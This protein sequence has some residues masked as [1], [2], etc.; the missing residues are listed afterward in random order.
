MIR[1]KVEITVNFTRACITVF[2]PYNNNE[3]TFDTQIINPTFD[4]AALLTDLGKR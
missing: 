2:L 1:V 4:H 3:D